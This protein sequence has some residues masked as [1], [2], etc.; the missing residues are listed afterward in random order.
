MQYV[1][2]F[3]MFMAWSKLQILYGW[4]GQ[5]GKPLLPQPPAF[6]V[7]GVSDPYTSSA[8]SYSTAR[9]GL[10]PYH[11][12]WS[13]PYGVWISMSASMTSPAASS[14]GMR[15]RKSPDQFSR[16]GARICLG[17]GRKC[18]FVKHKQVRP[19]WHHWPSRSLG[20]VPGSSNMELN[21]I[22]AVASIHL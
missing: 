19:A 3:S 1:N 15:A 16:T 12:K 6:R 7:S 4:L 11:C 22:I 13:R 20:D 5:A 18:Q 17:A 9:R 8:R 2:G 10:Y 14:P 21:C